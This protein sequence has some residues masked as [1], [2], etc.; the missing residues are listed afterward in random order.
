MFRPN[1]TPPPFVPPTPIYPENSISFSPTTFNVGQ[2]VVAT[3]HKVTST[4]EISKV[5]LHLESSMHEPQ[6]ISDVPV[7]PNE[8]DNLAIPFVPEFDFD[9]FRSAYLYLWNGVEY[10]IEIELTLIS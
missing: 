5:M 1:P 7:E 6:Q 8:I 10:G 4:P 3:I 9:T 2:N